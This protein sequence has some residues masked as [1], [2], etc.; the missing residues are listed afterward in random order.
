MTGKSLFLGL[1][2]APG[3]LG[4]QADPRTALPERP[5]VA[6]HA[7]TVA[8]GYV[9]LETGVELDRL[10]DRTVL[11]SVPTLFKFGIGHRFQLG[12]L[13]PLVAPSGTGIGPGDFGAG[14]KMRLGAGFA[15]FPSIKVPTG[16]R[17]RGRGTGTTDV[18]LLLIWSRALGPVAMDLNAGITRRSG[19]GSEAPR[20]A[21]LWTASFGGV[22][23]GPVGWVVEWFGYPETRGPAGSASTVAL[24]AGPT[25]TIRPWLVLDV[26]G[27]LGVS[28][29]QPDALYAGLTMNLGRYVP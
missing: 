11:T 10:P 14:V 5:T 12:V 24:L 4:A 6:T 18:S 25:L 27:I 15:V 28:G 13:L 22:A 8:S 9:E 19:D 26:G 1:L 20:T 3:A 2:L 21:T 7:Q 16:S 29:P 23:K 17:L